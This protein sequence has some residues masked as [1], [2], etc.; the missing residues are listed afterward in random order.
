MSR[1]T[2]AALLAFFLGGL[3]VHKFYLGNSKLGIL[4]LLFFWTGIP[5]VVGLI[6]SIQY[7]IMSDAD[8]NNK[9]PAKE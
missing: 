5:A 1:R 2:S 7:F 6:E 8:F 4:Y 9:F 3:G